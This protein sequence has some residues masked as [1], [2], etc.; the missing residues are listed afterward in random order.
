VTEMGF[1]ERK[2]G[3]GRKEGDKGKNKKDRSPLASLSYCVWLF[4]RGVLGQSV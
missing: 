2:E 1:R 3:R 4:G